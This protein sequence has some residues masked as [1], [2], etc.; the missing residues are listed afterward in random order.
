MI[1]AIALA[2]A[3]YSTSVLDLE[4]VACFLELQEIQ[5]EPRN[6]ANPPVDF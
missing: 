5:L 6:I 4:M 2:R 3:L 1:S